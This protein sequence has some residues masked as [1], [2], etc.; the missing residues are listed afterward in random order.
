MPEAPGMFAISWLDLR[1]LPVR[2]DAAGLE[3]QYIGAAIRTDGV[4]LWFIL[5]ESGLHLRCRYPD[6]AEARTHVGAW[7]DLL[8]ERL[9]ATARSSAGGR[10][11]VD[12]R[13]FRVQRAARADVPAVVALLADDDLGRGRESAE[14]A[15]YEAAFDVVARDSS[16]YLA[17][18]RDEADVVVATMQLT[19]IPGLLRAGTTRLQI[20]GL[21][22]AAAERSHGLGAAMLQWAHAHGRARGASLSQ[23]A[24]DEARERARTF[25]EQLGYEPSHV[26]LK[27]GL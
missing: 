6:T 10:L 12:G 18:V 20:E 27:R 17:V 5:D 24:T 13:R 1:R 22:V 15:R 11:D 9:R 8:V 26:G 14:E 3:A 16:Q 25:Y 4:M 19:I 23:V 7:L 2:V 21:R